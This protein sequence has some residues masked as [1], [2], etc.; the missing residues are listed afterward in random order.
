MRRSAWYDHH[1]MIVAPTSS[2]RKG[3]DNVLQ[4]VYSVFLFAELS[5]SQHINTACLSIRVHSLY[6]VFARPTV[7]YDKSSSPFFLSKSTISLV[8]HALGVIPVAHTL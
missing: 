3:H 5:G 2:W 7:R 4:L 6:R 1:T 8:F